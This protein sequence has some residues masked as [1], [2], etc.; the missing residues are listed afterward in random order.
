[1]FSEGEEWERVQ[2][3]VNVFD[4]SGGSVRDNER[5]GAGGWSSSDT[6]PSL[7]PLRWESRSVSPIPAHLS[8]L[9][10]LALLTLSF[11]PR[12]FAFIEILGQAA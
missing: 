1:M 6:D 10:L 12:D 5:T 8:L 3:K 2:F 11:S 4:C 7:M 9:A